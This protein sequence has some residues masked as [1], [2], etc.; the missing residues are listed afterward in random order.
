[1]HEQ[2]QS[3]GQNLR[4]YEGLFLVDD[5]R[6]SD[7]LQEVVDH[8]RGLLERHGATIGTLEKWDSRRL[9]YEI[10]GKRRGTYILSKFEGDPAQIDALRHDF[11]ISTTVLRTMILT[12]EHVGVSLE[13][14][15]DA[16]RAKRRKVAEAKLGD[17]AEGAEEGA[18]TPAT[19]TPVAETA[20]AEEAPAEAPAAAEAEPVAEAAAEASDEPEAEA[21]AAEADVAET[22]VVEAP[23]AEE[24]P[25]E[26]PAAAEAEPATEA[27]AEASD[28][29]EAEAPAGETPVAEPEAEAEVE[30][31]DK[32]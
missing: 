15:E 3:R 11:Q 17:V 4:A 12:E 18:E 9:A 21:P 6:A 30:T 31:E 13:D 5:N 28:E 29:P 23:A 16:V 8:I 25:A 14:A 19:E 20:A 1:M 10:E 26:A 24:A 7:N 22:P 27:V 2:V 32:N